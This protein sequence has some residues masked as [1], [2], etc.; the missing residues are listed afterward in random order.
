MGLPG[1]EI[2]TKLR[3][4]GYVW[5]GFLPSGA[6]EDLDLSADIFNA[7][8]VACPGEAIGAFQGILNSAPASE[9]KA[10]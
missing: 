4:A 6:L 3:D 9:R 5:F 7:N 1:Q 8:F 2:L 10:R